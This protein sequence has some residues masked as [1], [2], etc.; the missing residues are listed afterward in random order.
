MYDVWETKKRVCPEKEEINNIKHCIEVKQDKDRE[1]SN[2][3]C[4]KE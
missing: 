4:D 3:F 1:E 2:V